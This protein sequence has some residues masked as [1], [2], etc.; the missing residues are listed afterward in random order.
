MGALTD[1]E[2]GVVVSPI[3]I[4]KLAHPLGSLF[5]PAHVVPQP[6]SPPVE[7][8][9]PDDAHIPVQHSESEPQLEPVAVQLGPVGVDPLPV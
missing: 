3:H 4:K 1:E 8:H 5:A 2:E 7:E 6:A 9:L